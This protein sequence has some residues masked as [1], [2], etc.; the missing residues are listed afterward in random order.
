MLVDQEKLNEFLAH[1]S[2]LLIKKDMAK[3]A[4]TPIL[5]ACLSSPFCFT[6]AYLLKDDAVLKNTLA[7]VGVLPI[8]VACFSYVYLLFYK[9]DKLQ[10][11]SYQ[12]RQD[13]LQMVMKKGNKIEIL[14]VS[15][16][17]IANPP[18]ERIDYKDEPGGTKKNEE[19]HQ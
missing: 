5:Y 1:Q 6:G 8:I 3:S 4:M 15:L 14:P 16:S 10:S 17:E 7:F 2:T 18:P 11:E 13:L 12:I 9:T 19:G